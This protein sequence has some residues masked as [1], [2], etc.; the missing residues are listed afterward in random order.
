M[1]DRRKV[2]ITRER[3]V[4]TYVEFWHTSYC[5]FEQGEE[6][7]DGSMHQFRASLV[8]TAFTFEAYLNHVG[9]EV[10]PP[11]IWKAVERLSP[12]DKLNAVAEA[13]KVPVD[14]GSRPWGVMKKL[15]KF[16]NDLAHGKSV[17]LN[18][19]WVVP[20]SEYRSHLRDLVETE[21]EAFCTRENAQRSRED[22]EGMVN[23]IHKQWKPDEG[24][25]LQ[26]GGQASIG[27]ELIE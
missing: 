24:F 14:F 25:T 11:P 26:I 4:K 13:L 10:F 27:A 7:E 5:L 21:W 12:V 23:A 8:F 16:R 19:E 3:T 2:R 1:S 9:E 18:D 20:L 22:V 6:N 15:F 17:P